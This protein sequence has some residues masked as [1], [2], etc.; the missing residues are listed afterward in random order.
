MERMLV[1]VF[2]SEAKA[3]EA[4]RALQTL[5][6]EGIIAVYASRVVA[7][8]EDGATTVRHTEDPMPGSTIGGTAVGG[9]LGMLG[10]P[11]GVAVGAATG[12][13]LGAATDLARARVDRDFVTDVRNALAP[14]K[15]AVVTEIYEES[16]GPVDARIEALGGSVFRRD[17]SDGKNSV[18]DRE[19]DV[20]E[21][22]IA[23]T[24]DRAKA[25]R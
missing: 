19:I 1:A 16:T 8:H 18:Y 7:R 17:L 23:R 2:D 25:R 12:F 3:Y 22:D 11:V 14:G 21:A 4:S 10:G 9:F 15:A 24:L 20:I 13:A 5:A 6:E